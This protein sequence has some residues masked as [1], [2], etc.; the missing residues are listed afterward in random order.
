MKIK[1]LLI[2]MLACSA[3]V[4]CTNEELLENN[5][6]ENG[7]D[8]VEQSYI[9]VK[10]VNPVAKSRAFQDGDDNEQQV[11]RA[12]FY[13]FNADNTAY[14]ISDDTDN[15]NYVDA[16]QTDLKPT[17]NSGS[18]N[19]ETICQ[20]VLVIDKSKKQPPTSIVAVLNYPLNDDGECVWGDGA[21]SLDDLKN[22]TLAYNHGTI[23]SGASSYNTSGNFV[24]TNS[25]YVDGT[26]TVM[27]ATP[28]APENICVTSGA[29]DAT[30]ALNHPVEIYV[31]RIAAKVEASMSNEFTPATD[32]SGTYTIK[33]MTFNQ[34]NENGESEEVTVNA[35]VLGWKVTNITEK[36]Y[37]IKH[38]TNSYRTFND[39]TGAATSWTWNDA[40]N[41]RSYWANTSDLSTPTH[42]WTFN[43]VTNNFDEANN[44]EYYNENTHPSIHSQLLVVAQFEVE[45]EPTPIA[46]WY[47]VKYTYAG[48]Q[49]AIANALKK[50]V[51]TRT[52]A[53]GNYEYTSVTPAEITFE[54]VSHDLGAERYWAEAKLTGTPSTYYNENQVAYTKETLATLLKTIQHAKIWG[55][56]VTTGEGDAAQRTVVGGGY[57]YVDIIQNAGTVTRNEEG[58]VTSDANIYGLVR[59]HWYQLTLNGLSGLGTPVYD[60]EK[61]I[62]TEKPDGDESY[63]AAEIN[64]LAWN[65]KQQS[66]TLE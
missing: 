23:K 54:Q 28:I 15:V 63:I 3:L 53:E 33:A 56:Y 18:N 60:P 34:I 7:K 52:G 61:I 2:G 45:G 5:E 8:Q 32:N 59:N 39:H 38:L 58:T 36:S 30:G 24:M 64:V 20:A 11:S 4:A 26:N 43:E 46:E 51:Y 50:K 16:N 37:L 40:G 42:P 35:R 9:S 65:I 29:E 14:E 31:E 48:L 17:Y 1:S 27:E 10:L 6:I 57:Y 49:T 19:F 12:R 47:G 25:V 21:K 22:A 66:V 44:W 13:L 41:F 55:N 62:K